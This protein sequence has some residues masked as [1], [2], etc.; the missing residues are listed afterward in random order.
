MS[1][2]CEALT[3]RR[4]DLGKSRPGWLVNMALAIIA[5]GAVVLYKSAITLEQ[6]IIIAL[7]LILIGLVAFGTVSSKKAQ[8]AMHNAPIRVGPTKIRFSPEGY[9]MEHP[10]VTSLTRWSHIPDV[11]AT[12]HGL[13]IVHSD[14]EYYPVEAKAFRDETEMEAVANQIKIWIAAAQTADAD[15]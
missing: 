15:S 11:I 1:E 3:Q 9:H 10:G 14:Y 4:R 2:A 8:T 13:I 6:A 7:L 5:A 12:P